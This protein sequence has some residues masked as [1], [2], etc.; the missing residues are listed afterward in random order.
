[1]NIGVL[2]LQRRNLQD[3]TEHEYRCAP[4]TTEE[5]T[6]QNRTDDDQEFFNPNRPDFFK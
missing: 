3:R 4:T 6:R 1:M 2:R 5:P